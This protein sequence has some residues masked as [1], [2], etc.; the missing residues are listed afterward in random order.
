[1]ESPPNFPYGTTALNPPLDLKRTCAVGDYG[2][3]GF[4]LYD[5]HGNVL[6]WCL[7]WYGPYEGLGETDPV[8]VDKDTV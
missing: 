3:N 2:A 4:G 6:E 5:V 8:R 1:M 7:D